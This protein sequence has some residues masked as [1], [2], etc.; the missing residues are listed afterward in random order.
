MLGVAQTMAIS[1]R[2][3]RSSAAPPRHSGVAIP[4]AV[5]AA[6]GSRVPEKIEAITGEREFTY[7]LAVTRLRGDGSAWSSDPTVRECLVRNP[8]RLLTLEDMWAVVLGTVTTTQ[9]ASEMGRLAQLLRAAGLI[10]PT[11]ISLPSGGSTGQA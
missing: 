4:R 3:P 10:A 6:V 11:P 1:V 2:T 5:A 8:F 9:A 7:R